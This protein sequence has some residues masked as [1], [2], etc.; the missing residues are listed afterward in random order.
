MRMINLKKVRNTI[1]AKI[2]FKIDRIIP[3][4]DNFFEFYTL[5]GSCKLSVAQLGSVRSQIEQH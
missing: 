1:L 3:L 4:V 2:V 5:L